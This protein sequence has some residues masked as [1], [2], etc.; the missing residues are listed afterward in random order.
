MKRRLTMSATVL[1][2]SVLCG[3][4]SMSSTDRELLLKALE[5][6]TV[7]ALSRPTTAP[8]GKIVVLREAVVRN[9]DGTVFQTGSAGRGTGYLKPGQ[10]GLNMPWYSR[11]A[12]IIEG[13][14][15]VSMREVSELVRSNSGTPVPEAPP[16][17]TVV[18][19][20]RPVRTPAYQAPQPELLQAPRCLNP[21]YSVPVAAPNIDITDA[22]DPKPATLEIP[23]S[24][25]AAAAAQ[26]AL[27][28]PASQGIIPRLP[29]PETARLKI[30]E[31]VQKVVVLP[32]K[33]VHV[34]THLGNEYT[35]SLLCYQ[36]VTVDSCEFIMRTDDGD[37][38]KLLAGGE[39]MAI[40]KSVLP[41]VE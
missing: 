41:T 12:V 22:Y 1:I 32:D 7:T 15:S 5:S 18:D 6:G 14:P 33:R 37:G 23:A 26:S 16:A 38:L 31:M 3:C 30:V 39:R 40:M 27:P 21:Q 17:Y 24:E 28:P 29:T 34:Y 11:D 2:L 20:V 36:T 13:I 9:P 19:D 35:G 4:T 8:Q 10:G 25:P